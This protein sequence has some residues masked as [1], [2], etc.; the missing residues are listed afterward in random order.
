MERSNTAAGRYTQLATARDPYLMRARECSTLTIPTLQ[1]PEG[2]SG[3]TVLPT[4][5]QSLGARG[6]NNLSAKLL[7]ALF[8]LNTP[9]FRMVVDDFTLEQVTKREGMRAE[10]EKAL[11]RVERAAMTEIETKAIR[12][13]IGEAMKHLINSGNVMLYMTPENGVRVF[14]LDRYVVSRDPMGNVL[15]HITKEDVSPSSVSPVLAAMAKDIPTPSDPTKTGDDRTLSIYTRVWRNGNH[16]KV[17]Q[18]INDI[19]VPG[20]EGSYPID[21]SPWLPLRWTKMDGEDYGRGY[22]EEYL[23]D[24]KSF[25][26]LSQVILE[27]SAAAAKVLFLVKP[28]GVTKTTTVSNSKNGA[29][30]SGD[31]EDV[32]VVQ[33]GKFADF[34]VALKCMEEIKDR[35]QFAFMLNTAVQ[36]AGERV[37]AEE[38]RYVANELEDAL[39]GVYSTLSQELQY[40]FVTRL[41]F[42]MERQKRLPVLPRELARP[43]ITTGLEAL[44]RGHDLNKLQS[45]LQVLAPLGPEVLQQ[46]MNVSDF[47]TRS[48]TALGIDM[49]GL[50][51]TADEVAANQQQATMQ[52]MVEKLGPKGM[53]IVRDQL[54]PQDTNVSSNTAR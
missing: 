24:L 39:G 45:F 16:F 49:S 13:S 5:Y 23:G 36:R 50:V 6:I 1:P 26:A 3:S 41:L 7:L 32:T 2:S 48:G 18:E 34:Q 54:K 38:I 53:D 28:N 19:I 4:P 22:V 11:N 20:S 21:K 12:V 52:Q 44:G 15:E 17:H 47:I 35:L 29:V 25:D 42:Q 10:V 43:T 37:T 40:P 30:L 27:G 46:Y 33:V 9:F 31:A 14:R 51:K 8:P